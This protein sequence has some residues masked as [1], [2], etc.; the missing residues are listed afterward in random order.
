MGS[1]NAQDVKKAVANTDAGEKAS[2]MACCKTVGSIEGVCAAEATAAWWSDCWDISANGPAPENLQVF[3]KFF[4]IRHQITESPGWGISARCS[5]FANR[6]VMFDPE[7]DRYICQ[8]V[9]VRHKKK[10]EEETKKLKQILT[11]VDISVIFRTEFKNGKTKTSPDLTRADV[12]CVLVYQAELDPGGIAPLWLV[13]Y[14]AKMGFPKFIDQFIQHCHKSFDDLPLQLSN[15]A[16]PVGDGRHVSMAEFEA[17]YEA[18]AKRLADE[19]AAT[20]AASADDNNG[21]HAAAKTE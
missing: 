5:I 9:T 10:P 4:R 11:N 2:Q 6:A 12:R 20:A 21:A 13:R 19:D 17:L 1:L 7:A 14:F 18:E 3:S 8:A 16:P 15:V